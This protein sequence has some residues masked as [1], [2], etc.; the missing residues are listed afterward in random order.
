MGS[1]DSMND[2]RRTMFGGSKR[3]SKML[4]MTY[5]NDLK[6]LY[7]MHDKDDSQ[8]LNEDLKFFTDVQQVTTSNS[9]Y[10]LVFPERSSQQ[11]IEIEIIIQL[12]FITE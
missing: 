3:S 10:L 6:F 7:Q 5:P 8:L 2:H 1:D 11:Q 12:L 4:T 9:I